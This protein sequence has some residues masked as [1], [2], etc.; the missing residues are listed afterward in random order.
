MHEAGKKA[1]SLIDFI[2]EIQLS[3]SHF[4]EMSRY[5]YI[6]RSLLSFVALTLRNKTMTPH[7][8]IYITTNSVCIK[9]KVL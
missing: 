2:E 5:I 9:N 1:A 8:D 7:L 6:V 3:P 4:I